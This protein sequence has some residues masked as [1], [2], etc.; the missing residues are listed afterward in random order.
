MK[1]YKYRIGRKPVAQIIY[2][3]YG[4][5]YSDRQIGRIMSENGIKC[6]IRKPRRSKE[7]KNIAANVNDIVLRDYDNVNHDFEIYAT[8]VTYHQQKIVM[9]IMFI[10]QL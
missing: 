10:C 2:K 1:K 5:R 7:S 4:V 3:E 9:K 8:D 6:N